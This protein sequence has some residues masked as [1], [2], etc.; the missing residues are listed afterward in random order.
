M[1]INLKIAIGLLLISLTPTLSHAQDQKLD[2]SLETKRITRTCL[3]ALEQNQSDLSALTQYAFVKKGNK[4]FKPKIKAG[5]LNT[6]RAFRVHIGKF[7]KGKICHLNA[8]F[9]AGADARKISNAAFSEVKKNGYKQ[10][11]VKDKRGRAM[12]VYKKGDVNLLINGSTI[13]NSGS[14]TTALSF[15]RVV[16]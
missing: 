15:A 13:Y 12:Q 8:L 4:Y 2:L 10:T 5:F 7:G 9:V 14:P 16:F 1:Y 11:V 6:K 3:N